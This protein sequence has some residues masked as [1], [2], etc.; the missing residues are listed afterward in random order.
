MCQK[1]PELAFYVVTDDQNYAWKQMCYGVAG[2]FFPYSI[3]TGIKK[4]NCINTVWHNG[5]LQYMSEI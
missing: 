1:Q 5:T 2:E 4:A 3:A